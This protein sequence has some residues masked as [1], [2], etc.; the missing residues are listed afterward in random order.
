M[1]RL[2]D[3]PADTMS[4]LVARAPKFL[5][6]VLS[7]DRWDVLDQLSD[8]PEPNEQI[9]AYRKVL[10]GGMVHI[11]RANPKTRRT[12]SLWYAVA[13]YE[14]VELQPDDATMRDTTQWRQWTREQATAAIKEAAE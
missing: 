7:P 2:I 5:R 9:F 1:I 13:N 8:R 6:V 14:F 4:F 12:E 3:G 11:R 10:D